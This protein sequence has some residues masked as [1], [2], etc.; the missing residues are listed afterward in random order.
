MTSDG[1]T[2][3]IK[4]IDLEKLWNFVVYNYFIWNHLLLQNIVWNL[5]LKL[6]KTTDFSF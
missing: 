4:V 3:K 6:L 1:E 2:T 5:I